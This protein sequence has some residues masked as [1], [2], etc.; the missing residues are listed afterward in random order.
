MSL[1]DGS[2]PVVAVLVW[3]CQFLP[4]IVSDQQL[5]YRD[6]GGY[7]WPTERFAQREWSEGR[8]PLWSPHID[9]GAPFAANPVHAVF[10]PGKLVYRCFPF[11][12]AFKLFHAGHV[13]LA[14]VIM[15]FAARRLGLQEWPALIAS[16]SYA[17]SGYVFFQL[18][19]QP[20]LIGASWLPLALACSW[21]LAGANTWKRASS[22][23]ESTSIRMSDLLGLVL[24]QT[25][26]ILAGDVQSAWFVVQLVPFM[27]IVRQ[28]VP[29]WQLVAMASWLAFQCLWIQIPHPVF[30][31]VLVIILL[32]ALF[33]LGRS[34][35]TRLAPILG[36]AGAGILV[37][38]LSLVQTCRHRRVG[39]PVNADRTNGH[40]RAFEL[41]SHADAGMDRAQ[42]LFVRWSLAWKLAARHRCRTT[43]VLGDRRLRRTVD[44]ALPRHRV[45]IDHSCPSAIRQVSRDIDGDL[46]TDRAGQI[47]VVQIDH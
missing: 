35:R 9:C 46:I 22:S 37:A 25:M 8:L 20:Y 18:Y 1:A 23:A 39:K 40:P 16:L 6:A 27:L 17:Y 34:R 38:L 44:H 21:C 12:L 4:T 26:I 11:P 31:A 29:R 13:L 5:A 42:S 28:L 47:F 33:L 7:Y 41:S 32:I 2:C 43:R 30:H 10:Y 19:N 36:F 24:S 3:L 14:S 45:V 15:L